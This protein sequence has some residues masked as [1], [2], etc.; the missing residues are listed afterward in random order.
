MTDDLGDRRPMHQRT[1]DQIAAAVAQNKCHPG[2]PTPT[3]AELVAKRRL[4]I[5]TVKKA[6]DGREGRGL[7]G[8]AQGSGS[9]TP[10][11]NQERTAGSPLRA[12]RGTL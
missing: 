11:L 3:E 2:E 7:M 1:S 5:G 12:I 6:L 10:M 9:C 4:S 8:R